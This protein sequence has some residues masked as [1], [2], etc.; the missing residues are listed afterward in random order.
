LTDRH[1]SLLTGRIG[2]DWSEIAIAGDVKSQSEATRHLPSDQPAFREF[3]WSWRAPHPDSL[4]LLRP[5]AL[6]NGLEVHGAWTGDTL[7]GRA[8]VFSDAIWPSRDPRANAYLVRYR[9]GDVQLAAVASQR[10]ELFLAVDRPD[11]AQNAREIAAE[12]R[13]LDSLAAGVRNP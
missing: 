9:C 12:E 11:S 10:L 8:H 1:D 3:F 4:E 13:W 6:S 2:D 7:L 5:A